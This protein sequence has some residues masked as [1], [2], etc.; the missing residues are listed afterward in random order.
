M[1]RIS[2]V[3]NT[4]ARIG[5]RLFRRKQKRILKGTSNLSPWMS[6]SPFDLLSMNGECVKVILPQ[7]DHYEGTEFLALVAVIKEEGTTAKR[8][9]ILTVDDEGEPLFFYADALICESGAILYK[10]EVE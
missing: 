8:I 9:E 1:S 6:L 10:V 3:I 5:R 4:L 7:T 2:T